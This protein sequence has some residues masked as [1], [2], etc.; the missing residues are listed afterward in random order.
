MKTAKSNTTQ[1]IHFFIT[2]YPKESALA[3][4]ALLIASFAETIGIGALLPLITIIIGN[5]TG[6]DNALSNL[7]FSL[8]KWLQISPTLANLLATIVITITLKALIVFQAMKY[9]SYVAVD[10]TRDFRMRLIDKLMRAEWGYF[11]SLSIG[12]TSNTISSE[13]ARAGHC[14]LLFGRTISAFLQISIYVIAAFLVSWQV[15]LLAIV[16]GGMIAFIAKKFINMSRLAGQNLTTYMNKML[17]QLNDS[18]SGIKPLKAMGQEERFVKTLDQYATTVMQAQKKQ[19]LSNQLLQIM[20]EPVAVIL[21]ASGLFYVL[22]YTDTPAASVLLLAF[23]FYRLLTNANLLQSFYQNMV[24]NEAAV[25]GLIDEINKAS[26]KSEPKALGQDPL[27]QKHIVVN[28]ISLSYDN[29]HTILS[30]FSTTIPIHKISVLFGPSG[31]GKTSLV[32]ALLGLK[33]IS[34][35]E[36][37]IDD[38]NLN[39]INIKKWRKKIGYVPQE[40]FLF[41]DTIRQNITLGDNNYAEQDIKEALIQA[42]ALDFVEKIPGGTDSIVGERGGK[43]SGGQR[44]RIALSRALIRKPDLIILDEATSGLDYQTEKQILNTLQK[45]SENIT[46]IMISHNPS[47]LDQ[48]DHVIKIGNEQ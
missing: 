4:T 10:V 11:S 48:V 13:A 45:L 30:N 20:Y 29:S 3:I 6:A 35:G 32:D 27:L 39:S 22:T 33:T 7:I 42:D 37:L 31:S 17:A 15:S 24:Q 38:I 40:T 18:L 28:N 46:I 47:I 41:H 12:K 8:Y 36:I 26:A 23:L 43:I 14:Y 34:A 16:M 1:L 9:V 2:S 44:Q 5:E 21:L 25:W 19:A